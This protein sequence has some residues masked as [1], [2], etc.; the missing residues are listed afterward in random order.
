MR[1]AWAQ[2]IGPLPY[3]TRL[4]SARL[5][6]FGFGWIEIVGVSDPSS[7]RPRRAPP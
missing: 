5:G 1:N 7:F 6:S 4:G 3:G 2:K